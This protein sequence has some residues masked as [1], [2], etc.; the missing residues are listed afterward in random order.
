MTCHPCV[1]GRG[2]NHLVLVMDLA[3]RLCDLPED[4][5]PEL[6]A[7]GELR[8]L[9]RGDHAHHDQCDER[10]E[11]DVLDRSLARLLAAYSNA[12]PRRTPYEPARRT[13]CAM[14][15]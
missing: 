5:R 6:L 11:R 14:Q 2:I 3:H 12:E 8:R 15:R 1:R 13:T 9:H 4:Q 7:L 10:D